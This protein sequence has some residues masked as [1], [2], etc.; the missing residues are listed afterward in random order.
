MNKRYSD[1]DKEILM[2][3]KYKKWKKSKNPISKLI[4]KIYEIKQRELLEIKQEEIKKIKKLLDESD[5]EFEKRL[6][7]SL[8]ESRKNYLLFSEKAIDEE[9][10]NE[11]FHIVDLLCYYK[12]SKLP[13]TLSS[14]DAFEK[15]KLRLIKEGL[16]NEK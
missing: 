12:P 2:E 8:L 11:L 7:I 3:I 10:E 15:I 9:I 6:L 14:E 13:K 5:V 4:L 16:W 1:F